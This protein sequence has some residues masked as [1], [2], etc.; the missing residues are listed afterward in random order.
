MTDCVD[1]L[2]ELSSGFL[3]SSV[4]GKALVKGVDDVIRTYEVYDLPDDLQKVVLTF[5][6]SVSY[7]V[8]DPDKRAEY[9]GY[10]DDDKLR[11]LAQKF[12]QEVTAHRLVREG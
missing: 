10:V 8:E 4:D 3:K 9:A 2:V 6:D 7:Y 12:L 11:G 5:Q 1:L